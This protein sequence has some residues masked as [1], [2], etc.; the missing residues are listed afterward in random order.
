M[1]FFFVSLKRF[2]VTCNKSQKSVA[3]GFT[4]TQ[5]INIAL[6]KEDRSE[7]MN[8]LKLYPTLQNNKM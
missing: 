5:L 2:E 6:L 8:D 7:F 4:P 3:T 1:H